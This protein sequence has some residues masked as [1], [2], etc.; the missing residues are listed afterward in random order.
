MQNMYDNNSFKSQSSQ[1]YCTLY[2]CKVKKV[3]VEQV[4][5]QVVSVL[6]M[7]VV[8]FEPIDSFKVIVKKRLRK[9]N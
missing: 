7:S 6:H 4:N 9:V 3:F 5:A 8:K 2:V 1:K